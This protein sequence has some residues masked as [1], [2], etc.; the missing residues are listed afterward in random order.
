MNKKLLIS[1][2]IL[3]SL[4][5]GKVFAQDDLEKTLEQAAIY[6]NEAIDLYKQDD[7]QKSIDYTNTEYIE[8]V[9][10]YSY[11]PEFSEPWANT[12]KGNSP[13]DMTNFKLTKYY[14][15]VA[16]A[17]IQMSDGKCAL[18]ASLGQLVV[19]FDYDKIIY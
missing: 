8:A 12:Y 9:N 2:L 10:L 5:G 4:M 19:N 13:I 6:Y 11:Y 18:I 1:F 7:V 15:N 16:L 14:P 3:F 17:R